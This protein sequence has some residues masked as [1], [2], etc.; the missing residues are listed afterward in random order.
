MPVL[1]R[2]K[3]A[4]TVAH[5][6]PQ[7]LDPVAARHP[8]RGTRADQVAQK[9]NAAKKHVTSHTLNKLRRNNSTPLRGDVVAA[10]AALKSEAEFDL[11]IIGSGS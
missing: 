1:H 9:R 5:S 11:Q 6:R 8:G 3:C 2:P 10:V 4:V 7:A